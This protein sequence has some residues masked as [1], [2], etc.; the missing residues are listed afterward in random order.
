MLSNCSIYEWRQ[1][2]G[3]KEHKHPA[4]KSYSPR[5]QLILVVCR[6]DGLCNRMFTGHDDQHFGI[7]T[8]HVGTNEPVLVSAD[9][10]VLQTNDEEPLEY[11]SMQ[12]MWR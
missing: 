11:E 12:C 3:G 7:T 4:N 10:G 5:W 8:G 2:C 6:F 9:N 1:A